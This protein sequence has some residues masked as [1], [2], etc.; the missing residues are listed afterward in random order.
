MKGLVSSRRDD[1][2]VRERSQEGLRQG[3]QE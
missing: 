3:D 2:E 1:K